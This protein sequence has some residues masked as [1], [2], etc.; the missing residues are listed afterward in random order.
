MLEDSAVMPRSERG[1]GERRKE[2][3]LDGRVCEPAASAVPKQDAIVSGREHGTHRRLDE[4]LKVEA[5][6]AL[7]RISA[8]RLFKSGTLYCAP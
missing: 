6:Q 8:W 4:P 5:R 7:R 2:E 1:V 3:P